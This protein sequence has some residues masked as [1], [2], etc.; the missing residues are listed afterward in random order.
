MRHLLLSLCLLLTPIVAHAVTVMDTTTLSTLIPDND[1]VGVS[2]TLDISN[3]EALEIV[4]VQVDLEISGGWNGD[5]YVY[6]QHGDNLAVLL[7]RV[8]RTNSNPDGFGSSGMQVSLLDSALDDIHTSLPD[9]GTPTGTYQPDGRSTDPL[10]VLDTDP[11]DA[12]LSVFNGM[13]ANGEWT[14]FLA[15]QSA[16][17]ESTIVSWTLTIEAV[18]EP[19]AAML[20]AL[21]A[22][23]MLMR[24][25][26]RTE[27]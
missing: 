22:V 27:I 4:S 1:A 19:S 18:P 26:R 25:S 21:G 20:A 12:M 14:L 23:T 24:R 17:D 2:D 16:G 5:L 13:D 9:T 10:L 8:G 11:R 15:D 6:L 7:N 3:S